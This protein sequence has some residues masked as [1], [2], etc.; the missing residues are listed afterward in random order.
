M[1]RYLAVPSVFDGHNVVFLEGAQYSSLLAE[2]A[3]QLVLQP[4]QARKP[5]TSHI[6]LV[7]DRT[8]RDHW[9]WEF[10]PRADLEAFLQ[11]ARFAEY[12][13]AAGRLRLAGDLALGAWLESRYQAADVAALP[14]LDAAAVCRGREEERLGGLYPV[15]NAVVALQSGPSYLGPFGICG[16]GEP[17]CHGGYAWVEGK[18]C[19][20][21]VEILS[22]GICQVRI[23]P[24]RITRE[25]LN[26]L[27][28]CET[29]SPWPTVQPGR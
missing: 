15:R 4:E 9:F 23:L 25:V 26:E 2:G 19:L 17:G 22:V 24:F 29:L 28:L 7:V 8:K 5:P 10:E 1:D 21:F 3:C 14:V 13:L 27:S 16:C 18:V 11:A 6:V 20:L 12:D